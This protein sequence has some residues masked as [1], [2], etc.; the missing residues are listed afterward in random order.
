MSFFFV[1][2]CLKRKKSVTSWDFNSCVLKFCVKETKFLIGY[3]TEI[4]KALKKNDK[5][6]TFSLKSN[7]SKKCS[8][9][10][11]LNTRLEL[12]AAVENA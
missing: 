5:K 3:R 1:C 6:D 10:A 9:P 4:A 7:S 2:C 8:L 11:L 12:F